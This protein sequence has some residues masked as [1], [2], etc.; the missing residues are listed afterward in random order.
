M[1]ATGGVGDLEAATGSLVVS[2]TGGGP[3]PPLPHG[4]AMR[5]VQ[6]EDHAPDGA[7]A[8]SRPP[9]AAASQRRSIIELRNL[10][11]TYLLGLEGVPAL[12]GVSLSIF[13]GEFIV[14]LGKSGSGK[15]SLL[16]L[17][18]TIDR[19]T[20][21]DLRVGDLNIYAS[22]TD[23]ELAAL[24]LHALGFGGLVWWVGVVGEG[25]ARWVLSTEG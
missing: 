10:H 24:R 5:V 9:A 16:N 22:T 2:A 19:P 1:Q 17:I 4:G 12:R 23:D 8:S 13:P 20:R 7:S 21:G 6:G 18:G 25:W 11:K 14:I 15:T 3:I